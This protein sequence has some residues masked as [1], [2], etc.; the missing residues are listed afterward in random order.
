VIVQIFQKMCNC[1]FVLLVQ[2]MIV[3]P[4]NFDADLVSTRGFA[5]LLL[6]HGE[7]ALNDAHL[8]RITRS[9]SADSCWLQGYSHV[10]LKVI[11]NQD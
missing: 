7:G 5:R 1:S 8:C 6:G 10:L 9:D 3:D 4:E 11:Q 2:A